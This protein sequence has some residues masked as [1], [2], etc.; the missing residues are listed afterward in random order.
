MANILSQL[1]VE[2][3]DRV[4]GPARRVSQ[5]L[6]GITRS[7]RDANR[8]PLSFGDRLDAAITRNNRALDEARGRMVD[9]VGTLYVLKGAL[10]APV[11]SAIQLETAL[12]GLGAKANLS[13]EQ[14]QSIARSAAEAGQRTNQFTARM[15]EAQ[16]FLVGMGLDVDRSTRAIESIGKAST[17]TGSDILDMSKAAFSAMQNLRIAPEQLAQ[18]FDIM[19]K[20]GKEGG[21]E[22]RDM[23]QY[24][25]AIT[26]LASTKGMTGAKGLADIAAA[27]Q[28]VRRT[29]GDSSEAATNFSN[30][31]QKINA[32]DAIRNFAKKGIDIQKVLKDAEAQ[33]ASPL[34][35]AL[36]AINRAIGG[37]LSRLGE[38][39]ADA[40]VQKGLIPLL[41]GMDD[42]IALREEALGASGVIDDDFARMMETNAEKL[43]AFQIAWENFKADLGK[44]L[45]PALGAIAKALTPILEG[46]GRFVDQYPRLASALVGITVGFV[47]LKAAISAISFIGLMGKGG[48]L[49]ATAFSVR[50]LGAALMRLRGGAQQAIALQTAL[51]AMSGAKFTG[52]A[53]LAVGLKGMVMSVPGIAGLVSVLGRL[54]AAVAGL[55]AVQ[56]GAAAF[57]ATNLVGL[58]RLGV[59]LKAVLAAIPGLSAIGSA[60]VAIGTA[61]AAI[62]APVWGTIAVVVAA[63][64][65]AGFLLW[66]YWQRVSAVFRGFA[67]GIWE[68][69]KPAVEWMAPAFE[70]ILA[71]ANKIGEGFAWA[72]GKIVEFFSWLG[73][74][75]QQEQLTEGQTAQYENLGRRIAQGLVNA[76]TFIPRKI[77]ELVV[78][79]G[80]AVAQ[81][82]SAIVNGITAAMSGLA[83]QIGGILQGVVAAIVARMSGFAD[84]GRSLMRAM[85]DGMVQVFTDMKAW[86][87]RKVDELV[88]IAKRAGSAVRN[89]FGGGDSGG[90]GK[91]PGARAK[92][93]PISQGSTYLVGERGPELI[94][95]GRSGYV[96]PAGASP[97][98][99]PITVSPV[100]NMTFNGKADPEMTAEHI[101]RV[102]RDEVREVFRGVYSDTGMR[103]A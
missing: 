37:D 86:M 9:A 11:Q 92:G 25:P 74:F 1:V 62:S 22:L 54:K 58:A 14:L 52:M 30:I 38:L 60:I 55:G 53:K 87:G 90:N 5:S 6:N 79:V 21:F 40:Q 3:L 27:L 12:A 18:S 88:N 71:L 50:T 80:S 44:A 73:S 68:A 84:A 51:A 4:S 33:G 64:A 94:T 75:F 63:V 10:T 72:K 66:K 100:F 28:I 41:Q 89:F 39:F 103:F 82:G 59:A 31:L 19:A 70:P 78:A 95:P 57:N 61:A 8:A 13:N 23:A 101:R 43:K 34:E 93:G 17:A 15:I 7:V 77:A 69:V 96:N 24:L 16:D 48:A 2:L 35:A 56:A 46:F 85:W 102:L 36:R 67:S 98:G 42:Y 83:A 99:G 81:L 26:G 45:I 32:N 91:A 49:S 65:A 76:I 97:Q 20:A 29:A 47:A